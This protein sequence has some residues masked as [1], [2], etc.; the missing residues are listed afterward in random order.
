MS[1]AVVKPREYVRLTYTP[2][3]AARA[4]TVWAYVV[5]RSAGRVMYR[6]VN[7][8]GDDTFDGGM[9]DGVQVEQ[10]RLIVATPTEALRDAGDCRV[11]F[12]EVDADRCPCATGADGLPI[13]ACGRE[14]PPGRSHQRR[15]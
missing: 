9:K 6:E 13:A 14:R 1:D 12:S 7:V 2:G 5:R 15:A 11:V 4:R 10:Q 3:G 8:E